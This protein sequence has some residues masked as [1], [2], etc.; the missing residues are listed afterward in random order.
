[1]MSSLRANWPRSLGI[2]MGLLVGLGIFLGMASCALVVWFQTG[3]YPDARHIIS[4]SSSNGITQLASGLYRWKGS[5]VTY[6]E[7]DDTPDKI[8]KWYGPRYRVK[9]FHLGPISVA[10]I[11]ND[12]HYTPP[13]L[14]RTETQLEVSYE[15]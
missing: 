14:Y 12:V 8:I 2:G 15:P 5:T 6:F 9:T 13:I 1:M 11:T 4:K 7:S 10:L 3:V